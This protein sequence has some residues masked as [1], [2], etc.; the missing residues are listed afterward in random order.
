[1]KTHSIRYLVRGSVRGTIS[2]NH[3]TLYGA[4]RSCE[5][6][7]NQCARL[8]GGAYSDAYV[9]HADGSPLSEDE[10]EEIERIEDMLR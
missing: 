6:D 5:R 3:R 7:R 8:S 4:V 1:M 10:L 2:T 9:E